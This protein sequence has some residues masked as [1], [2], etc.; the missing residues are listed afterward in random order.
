[1]AYDVL[2]DLGTVATSGLIFC[3]AGFGLNYM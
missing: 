1:M 2:V 3:P